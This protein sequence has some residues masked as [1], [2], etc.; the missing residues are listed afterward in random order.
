MKRAAAGMAS[1]VER[2]EKDISFTWI[3]AG[4]VFVAVCT[5]I[6]TFFVFNAS[7]LISIVAATV[8][9]ILAFFFAAVSGYLVGIM[10]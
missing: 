9:I 10:D 5:F 2:T 8:M 6:I 3:M 1:D 4:I 7:L